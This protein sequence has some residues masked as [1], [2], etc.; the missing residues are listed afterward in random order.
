[1]NIK[2]K[3]L[4]SSPTDSAFRLY[5]KMG[6]LLGLFL[7]A[8]SSSSKAFFQAEMTEFRLTASSALDPRDTLFVRAERAES[9]Q[10]KATLFVLSNPD[11]ILANHASGKTISYS[12]KRGYIDFGTEQLVLEFDSSTRSEQKVIDLKT[13]RTATYTI[14][15]SKK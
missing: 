9:S 7:L 2:A 15:R 6:F 13:L 3:F 12:S 5:G 11:I 10:L 4:R 14:P 1:M 8:H